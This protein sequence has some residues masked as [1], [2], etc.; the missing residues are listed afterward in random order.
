MIIRGKT[1]SSIEEEEPERN[2]NEII[3]QH[4]VERSLDMKK[5]IRVYNNSGKK[6]SLIVSSEPINQFFSL[7]IDKK[8]NIAFQNSNNYNFQQFTI[9]NGKFYSLIQ[10]AQDNTVI[11]YTT[12]L[13]F[14]EQQKW[15]VYCKNNMMDSRFINSLASDIF[16]LERGLENCADI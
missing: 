9:E 1:I 14:E 13:Y 2:V 3:R 16:L 15:K 4:R 11:Y 7:E 10:D 12:F 5:V 8:G 6:A